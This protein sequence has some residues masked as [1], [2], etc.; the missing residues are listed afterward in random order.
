M[1]LIWVFTNFF[2]F[3]TKLPF[4]FFTLLYSMLSHSIYQVYHCVSD[5]FTDTAISGK[6]Q[7]N[8]SMKDGEMKELKPWEP[9]EDMDGDIGQV[10]GPTRMNTSLEEGSRSHGWAAEEMFQ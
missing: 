1:K 5:T 2:R 3:I 9:G 7:T 4:N 10:R 6:F 8:G